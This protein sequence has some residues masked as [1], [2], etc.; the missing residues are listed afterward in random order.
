MFITSFNT[1]F[2]KFDVPVGPGKDY[3]FEGYF[4]WTT[5]GITRDYSVTVWSDAAVTLEPVGH[6]T[7]PT[8]F[9]EQM[10]SHTDM[11]GGSPADYDFDPSQDN[12]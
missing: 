7:V 11:F 1:K 10:G 2:N 8:T 4:N 12:R 9:E 3:E 5:P 6:D